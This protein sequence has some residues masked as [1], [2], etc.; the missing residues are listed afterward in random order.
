MKRQNTWASRQPYKKPR[1]TGV[2]VT[3]R[4]AQ[5][6]QAKDVALLKRKVSKLSRGVEKKFLQTSQLGTAAVFGTSPNQYGYFATCLNIL[7]QGENSSQRIGDVISC[8]K[9]DVNFSV[10]SID[11]TLL[12]TGQVRCLLVVDKLNRNSTTAP[13]ATGDSAVLDNDAFIAQW[14]NAHPNQDQK[15]RYRILRDQTIVLQ[16][17]TVQVQ[18]TAG[19]N[20][21]VSQYTPVTQN[22]RWKVPL[23]EMKVHYSLDNTDSGDI[24]N[25]AIYMLFFQE[26]STQ[27]FTFSVNLSSMLHYTDN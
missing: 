3:P 18:V 15:A 20:L 4:S 11:G 8:T 21:G 22:V 2:P 12:P 16:P 9:L 7:G 13:P 1:L 19:P 14:A 17:Q 23:K 25:N 10:S 27:G 6:A 24:V 26:R 5:V